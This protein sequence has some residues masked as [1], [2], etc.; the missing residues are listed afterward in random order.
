MAFLLDERK[1]INDSVF[2]MED[3]LNSQYSRFLDK[4]PT[5]TTYYNVNNIE[6]TADSGFQSVERV[7]GA[8]S[9][10]RYNKV[11]NFPIYG[12]EQIIL[13]LQDEDQGLDSEYDGEGII[14]P[15]TVKPLPYDFFIIDYLGKQY[16]FQVTTI[17]YDTIK[18]NNFYRIGFKIKYTDN[19]KNEIEKQVTDKYNCIF[20]NIGTAEKCLIKEEDVSR[21]IELNKV[22]TLIAERYKIFFYNKKYNAFL[23]NEAEAGKLTYNLLYD[24][25][26]S[27]FI[28]SNELFREKNNYMTCYLTAERKDHRFLIEYND[29][30][31][32]ALEMGKI[33]YNK[34]YMYRIDY[35]NNPTSIFSVYREHRARDIVLGRGDN[36]Y[37]PYELITKIAK[38]EIVDD[39]NI[40][41]E[42]II[43]YFNKGIDSVY[44]IDIDKLRDYNTYMDYNF[45]TFILL[46][47]VL[48]IIKKKYAEFMGTN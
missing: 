39:D 14:L 27:E 46:P 20:T 45:E 9:P 1:F 31:Y 17:S 30:I 35:I 38:N 11:T 34:K 41:W 40:V 48:F 42:L 43:K 25:Y 4:T 19:D 23:F 12:I 15:N 26:Q 37:V 18:S 13:D 16:L 21:L 24:R 32:K 10:I 2:M 33:D 3:R 36:F 28:N 7:I 6:S 29:S 22:Y 44:T 47:I 5:F 8:D